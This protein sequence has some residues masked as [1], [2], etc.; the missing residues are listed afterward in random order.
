MHMGSPPFVGTEEWD[1]VPE[2]L[3]TETLKYICGPRRQSLGDE[4]PCCWLDLVTGTCRHYEHRPDIC[5]D[6]KRDTGACRTHREQVGITVGGKPVVIQV[7]EM[8]F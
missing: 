5:R 7:P 1:R 2:P 4:A 3:R 6:F 8:R